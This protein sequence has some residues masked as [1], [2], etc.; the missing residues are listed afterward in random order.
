MGYIE[1]TYS[2][3]ATGGQMDLAVILGN[4]A[5][6]MLVSAIAFFILH[7]F[8]PYTVVEVHFDPSLASDPPPSVILNFS[9][10]EFV[11]YVFNATGIPFIVSGLWPFPQSWVHNDLLVSACFLVLVFLFYIA[12]IFLKRK[13]DGR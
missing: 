5:P 3:A 10:G 11:Q 13:I 12:P 1:H 6:V 4:C 2:W 7:C 8:Y 9:A